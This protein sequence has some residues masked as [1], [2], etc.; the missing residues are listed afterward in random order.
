MNQ[1]I[2]NLLTFCFLY[3]G[4]VNK[5]D[6]LYQSPDYLMEKWNSLIKIP[7]NNSTYKEELKNIDL[8]NKW[9]IIWGEDRI[10][11]NILMF[12]FKSYKVANITQIID[13]FEKYIGSLDIYNKDYIVHPI[14]NESIINIYNR[15]V[16]SDIERDFILKLI[17][18]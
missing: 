3:N 7:N 2:K 4:F 15:C 12:I 17:L 13:I 18:S 6:L 5:S 10:P 1:R 9:V 11:D 8:Y 16:D 14:L